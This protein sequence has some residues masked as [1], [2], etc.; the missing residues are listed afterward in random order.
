VYSPTPVPATLHTCQEAR[1]QGLYQQVFSELAAQLGGLSDAEPRYV[2]L[3]LDIDMVS[4]G[5]TELS[6]FKPV[7]HLIRRLRFTRGH[8]GDDYMWEYWE[9]WESQEVGTFKNT[10]EIHVVCERGNFWDWCG[11]S[12]DI[13]WPCG[14][15]NVAMVN[16]DDGEVMRLLDIDYEYDRSLEDSNNIEDP[17]ELVMFRAGM[18]YYPG[19]GD[20]LPEHLY[21][22]VRARPA[23]EM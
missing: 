7:A 20:E 22:S 9:R 21:T 5:K 16:P 2:Y 15:E 10:T 8:C 4:I 1:R 19:R 11:S 6:L 17:D 12:E 18:P 3:N 14:V 13:Y 23:K